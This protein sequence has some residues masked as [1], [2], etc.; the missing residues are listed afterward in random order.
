VL[1]R[2]QTVD[3][4]DLRVYDSAKQLLSGDKVVIVVGVRRQV[5]TGDVVRA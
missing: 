1:R 3:G 2:R 4:V 5:Q